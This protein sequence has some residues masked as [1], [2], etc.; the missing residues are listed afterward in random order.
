[1]NP[2]KVVASGRYSIDTDLRLGAGSFLELPFRSKLGFVERDDSFALNLE[3]CNGCGGCRKETPTMCPTFLVTGDEVLSTRGRANIIRAALDGRF[4]WKRSPVMAAQLEEVLSSCLSCKACKREC[5]SNVDLALLKADLLQA[6]HEVKRPSHLDRVVASAELFGRLGTLVPRLANRLLVAP[7]VRKAIERFIGIDADRSLLPFAR[8]RFD[9][10]FEK[11]KRVGSDTQAQQGEV[12]LW[13]DTWSRYHEPEPAQAATRVLEG[14]G[15]QVGIVKGR[16]CCGR[17]AFSR[18]FVERVR[19]LGEHNVGLLNGLGSAPLIFLEPS[20]FSM[21]VDEYLQLGIPEAHSVAERCWLFEDFVL[22]NLP[23]LS[24]VVADGP[25]LHFAVH[26]HCHTKAV[27]EPQWTVDRLNQLNGVHAELLDTA[28]CG[29]AGAF[30]LEKAK[31]KLSLQVASHLLGV[32]DEVDSSTTV[33]AGGA[34]CRHQIRE[35]AHRSVCH[36]AEAIEQIVDA[37]GTNRSEQIGEN[38]RNH[39]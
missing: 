26:A 28:C 10:W 4:K 38:S 33:I 6:R 19:R 2:G 8:M 29:M 24:D 37:R 20:C 36:P 15:F 5:P 9:R 21:F 27:S 30:G 12:L 1:M 17:P 39:E 7:A 3:Q 31:Q 14:L 35:L 25:P 18:G 16:R 32:L 23:S 22:G 34:S 13:D 11:R